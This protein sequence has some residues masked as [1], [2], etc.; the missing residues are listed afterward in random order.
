MFKRLFF[1]LLGVGLGLVLGSWVVR[2]LERTTE[3]LRPENL[4]SA[5]GRR[6]GGL[7]GRVRVAVDAGR[8]A[9][10]EKEAEL[11]A[12]FAREAAGD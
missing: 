2:R 4:A 3:S 7:G 10:A 11:R 12:S 6:A 5:A 1:M 8:L 9:A